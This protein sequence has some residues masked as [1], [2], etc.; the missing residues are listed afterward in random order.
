MTQSVIQ[1]SF[2]AGELSQNLFARVDLDKYHTGAAKMENFFVD[3]RGGASTRAGTEF[4]D[5]TKF[6][7]TKARL[8]PFIFSQQ[9]SYV[10]E[11]GEHYIRFYSNGTQLLNAPKNILGVTNA[12]PG[13]VNVTAHGYTT[14]QSIFIQGVGGMTVLN[15]QTFLAVNIDANHF[16]LQDLDGHAIDTSLFPAYTS[17]GTVSSVY[18][19]VAPWAAADLPLL[20][21]AQ[22][23]DVMTFTHNSYP[24][25]NLSRTGPGVFALATETIGPSLPAVTGTSAT[26]T[27]AGTLIYQYI[28]CAVTAAGVRGEQCPSFFAASKALD[29]TAAT[30]VVIE[31]AWTPNPDADHYDIFKTGPVPNTTAHQPTV[32]GYIGSSYIGSF[33]DNNIA[34]N[35]NDNPPDFRDPFASSNYPGCVTYFQ[36]RRVYGNLALSP[37][38]MDF[39]KTGSYSNFDT[40]F[41][42]I[43]S[44]AIQIALASGQVNQIRSLVPTSAGLIV[45]TSGGAFQVSGGSPLAAVTPTNVSALP[46]ASTGAN[47]LPPIRVNYDILYVQ[48]KGAIVRDL[49]YNFY[50]QSFYGYDRS[51]LSNH[52][53]FGFNL[54]EWGWSEEPFKTIWAIRND[55]RAL[56]LTYVP[57]QEVYGWAQH[58]TSGMFESVC[59]VPE[60]NEDVVYFIVQRPHG[61]DKARYVERMASRH[62]V[63][64]EDAWFVDCGVKL[65]LTR[66]GFG[67]LLQGLTEDTVTIVAD[68]G[69][70]FTAGWVGRVFWPD[71]GG[72]IEITGFTSTTI[73]TGVILEDLP[74]RIPQTD[75]DYAAIVSGTWEWGTP[76]TEITLPS[77]LFDHEVVGLVDGEVFGP[78]ETPSN[79]VLE[80]PTPATKI[81]IGIPYACNLQTL[82]L[83]VGDPTI[84]GRRKKISAITLR[85]NETLGIAASAE[86][87][88]GDMIEFKNLIEVPYSSPQQLFDGDTRNVLAGP[89]DEKGQ[90]SITQAYPLP[91]T[92]LG[93]IPEVTVGD[94]PA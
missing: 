42:A 93:V 39:S 78:V 28:V 79:G 38:E 58:Y 75:N 25:Y 51:A 45:F 62:F 70:P 86:G 55:G 72:K 30:S 9:Q 36:Q 88:D 64:V 31:L 87:F 17:G 84:Q 43:D 8:F 80:L 85:L 61:T 91:A 12:N 77:N 27:V 44:D 37:E 81:I 20:K 52:L 65:Q 16:S 1:S 24:I 50:T 68:A 69:T 22:S 46:Q 18:E 35:Y 29:P 83:D 2:A 5:R 13:A 34:P 23:A 11:I 89:W 66:P 48:S 49:S 54:N 92:I 67:L 56:S 19:L 73:L 32:F 33:E 71:L 53:F 26:P 60:G 10:L 14:G 40:S 21:F 74:N 3:Y 63:R 15:G 76:V 94:D 6:K 7:N 57:E 90:V 47:D 82:Y 59:V 4:I 41:G